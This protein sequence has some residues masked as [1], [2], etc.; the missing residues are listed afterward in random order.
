[1]KNTVYRDLNALSE[2]MAVLRGEGKRIVWTNGCFDIMH[3]G[4][5][6]TF[7]KCRELGDV[8]VVGLNGDG[9]PYWK[10]KP[11]RPIN[12]ETFRSIMLS[13]LR[14]VDFVYLFDDETP[15]EPVR[16]LRPDIVLKGGDYIQESIR[17]RG[18][19]E[20]GVI[21]LTEAYRYM[22]AQ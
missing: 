10:T 3:P 7:A 17:D 15:E 21:D 19:T 6:R 18:I 1:M 2:R 14:D 16:V 4:H 22:L 8:V 5:M 11:G 12:D 13:S 20:D 9:S